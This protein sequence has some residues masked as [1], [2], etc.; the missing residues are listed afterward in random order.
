[1]GLGKELLGSLSSVEVILTIS[2]PKMEMLTTPSRWKCCWHDYLCFNVKHKKAVDGVMKP[3]H[4]PPI[5]LLGATV[6]PLGLF[7]YGRTAD[8]QV[9]WI[10]PLIGTAIVG[11]SMLLTILPTE[12]YLADIYE[13]YNASAV[14]AGAILCAIFGAIFPLVGPPLYHKIGLGWGNSVLAFIAMAFL[15][16]LVIL[17]RY[18]ERIRNRKR[19][20][21]GR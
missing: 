13:L 2:E 5:M 18:G 16:A 3:E 15:P 7:L 11:F 6:L 21:Q 1:M 14:A 19:L 12:N 17:K 4:R 20:Y 8:K 10:A 9:H